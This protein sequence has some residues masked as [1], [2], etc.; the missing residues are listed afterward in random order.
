MIGCSQ[1]ELSLQING[2]WLTTIR[3]LRKVEVACA[4]RIALSVNMAVYVPT[5]LVRA[6]SMHYLNHGT[7]VYR[8]SVL[9]TGAVWGDDCI[10]RRAD[11]RS[12]PAR[13]LTYANV[14]LIPAAK[15]VS[16]ISDSEIGTSAG[17]DPP[18]RLWAV[19]P[20]PCYPPPCS[21]PCLCSPGG[22]ARSSSLAPQSTRRTAR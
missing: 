13:A 1:G 8:G 14:S 16:I 18:T 4:V 3:F 15:L 7:V 2:P 17:L 10:L 5:E 9:I 22:V 19:P 11:M 21:L 12:R 6:D 20:H